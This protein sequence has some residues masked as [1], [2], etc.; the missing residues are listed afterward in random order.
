M[1]IILAALLFA[2]LFALGLNQLARCL[3]RWARRASEGEAGAGAGA[4]GEGS[5]GARSGASPWRCMRPRL[6]RPMGVP[7]LGPHRAAV[8]GVGLSSAA[9]EREMPVARGA[10]GR[11]ASNGERRKKTDVRGP[12]SRWAKRIF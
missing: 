1:V 4:R 3:L 6:P 10:A 12:P 9:S 2:L 11:E 5:R 8:V 7:L